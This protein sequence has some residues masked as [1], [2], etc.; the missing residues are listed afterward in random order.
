MADLDLESLSPEM[1]YA[2]GRIL[3][4]WM[5][6]KDSHDVKLKFQSS[7]N[8]C[9]KSQALFE[10]LQRYEDLIMTGKTKE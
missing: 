1:A 9:D 5:V 10:A 4:T 8:C 3:G 7:T 2:L 6:F